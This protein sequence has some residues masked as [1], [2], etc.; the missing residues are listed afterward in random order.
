MGIVRLDREV[1]EMKT[2]LQ[3]TVQGMQAQLN[4]GMA[5]LAQQ[6]QAMAA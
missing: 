3:Q 1:Q 5:N 2:E 4:E 6:M